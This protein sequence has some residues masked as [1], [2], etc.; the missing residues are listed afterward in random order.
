MR[1]GGSEFAYPPLP[2]V[3]PAEYTL[4]MQPVIDELKAFPRLGVH[5]SPRDWAVNLVGFMPFGLLL[6]LA[7]RQSLPLLLATV[8]SALLSVSIEFGQL[9]LEGRISSVIDLVLNTV[10]GGLGAWAGNRLRPFQFAWG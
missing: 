2:L 7:W 10:S 9:F 8:L 6:A 4:S 5:H 3:T 1:V